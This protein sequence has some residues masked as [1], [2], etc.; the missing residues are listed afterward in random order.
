LVKHLLSKWG[1]VGSNPT[2]GSW[3]EYS[4]VRAVAMGAAPAERGRVS[5]EMSAV[6]E[7]VTAF[8]FE[9]RPCARRSMRSMGTALSAHALR[10]HGCCRRDPLASRIIMEA[11]C[12]AR[13]GWAFELGR[14]AVA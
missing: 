9:A 10:W 7:F 1:V 13:S 12:N 2:G 5:V 3:F 11:N 14:S 6:Q 8:D 4:D